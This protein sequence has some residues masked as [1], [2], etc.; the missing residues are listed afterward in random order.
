MC[1]SF[2]NDSSFYQLLTGLDEALAAAA[3]AD[4]CPFCGGVLHRACY[5]RKPRGVGRGLLG[6]AYQWRWSFCCANDGCRRRTTP[7][8]VRFLGRRVYL[9]VVVV[10]ATAL[11]SGLSAR[12]LAWL[13]QHVPLSAQTLAR[14][15]QWWQKTFVATRFWQR[16][17]GRLAE[18]LAPATLPAALLA[19][20]G[21]PLREAVV[22]LLRFI[23]PVS[24]SSG[25]TLVEG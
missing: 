6:L 22:A 24:T 19:R 10:L 8:S 21:A 2:L 13:G 18:P 9:G 15:R 12:R 16:A 11:H 3:Q 25:S 23:A 1:H 7:P 17:R 5:P 4:G 20:F 14:W